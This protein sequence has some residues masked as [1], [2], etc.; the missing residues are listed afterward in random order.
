MKPIL[1]NFEVPKSSFR[2][3]TTTELFALI[4]ALKL[5][6]PAA[7]RHYAQLAI[8]N[9][10][11]RMLIAFKRTMRM[12]KTDD[13]GRRFHQEL[14]NVRPNVSNGNGS[15]LIA[16]RVERRS[17]AAAIFSGERLEY[18]QVRQLPSDKEKVIG[19]AI[20]FIIWMANQFPSD[21]VAIEAIPNGN[22]IQRQIIT[23]AIIKVIRERM[24]PI[25]EVAKRDLFLAYGY[26]PLKCRKELREV[27][28]GL[29]PI[30]LG[31]KSKIFIQD[32]VALGLYVQVERHFLH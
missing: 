31:T 30:L 12:S 14:E 2:P 17:I 23:A 22:E 21:S 6:D 13:R 18:C 10:Q 5:S 16:I 8:Q 19:S 9:T 3:K 7:V 15:R 20:R 1:D 24:L 28:A 11:D 4:L 29:W 32:A 27:I 26:P 25:W